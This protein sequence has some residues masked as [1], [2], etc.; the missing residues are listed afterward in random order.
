[1]LNMIQ[2]IFLW[3][4]KGEEKKVSWVKWV[5]VCASREREGLEKRDLEIFNRTLVGKW[6]WSLLNEKKGS[7][8]RGFD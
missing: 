4:A 3:G 1:M 7:L 5:V 2:M 6:L 8:G